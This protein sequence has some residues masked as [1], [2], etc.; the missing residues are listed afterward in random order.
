MQSTNHLSP[1]MIGLFAL[2][3]I[4]A[5]STVF[6]AYLAYNPRVSAQNVTS[7]ATAN[8]ITVTGTGQVSYSP[9][10]ALVQVSIQTQNSSASAA[11]AANAMSVASVIKALNTIGI[12]NSSIQTQGYNLSPNYASCFSGPCV[13]QITGYSVTNSLQVN[14]T[15]N[16]PSQLGTT[17]GLVI[18]TSVNAGANG[19]SLSFGA[20]NSIINQLT[21]EALQNAVASASTQA[22]AIATSLGVTISGVVSSTQGSDSLPQ[23]YNVYLGA[24]NVSGATQTPIVPGTQTITQSVQVVYAIS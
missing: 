20:T 17:A 14:I 18:D 12:S 15:S 6:I 4:L 19:I 7:G 16:D 3:V 22:H 1:M 8:S 2:L 21:N 13:P 9:N 11:T 24:A 10:E 23:P 5:S